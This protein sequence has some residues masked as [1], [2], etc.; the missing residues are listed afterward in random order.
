[1][2]ATCLASAVGLCGRAASCL[3]WTCR[4]E[5]R[6][7]GTK[8]EGWFFQVIVG[9][10]RLWGMPSP[11]SSIRGEQADSQAWGLLGL[12]VSGPHP[13]THSAPGTP[14]PWALLGLSVPLG[15]QAGSSL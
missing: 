9:R 12:A 13:Q 2:L 10:G 6:G 8:Q 7:R 15:M 3:L 4:T 5:G 1:M 14:V 11:E